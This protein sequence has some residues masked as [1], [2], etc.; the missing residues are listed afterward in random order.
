[1]GTVFQILGIIFLVIVVV[2]VLAYFLIRRKLKAIAKALEGCAAQASEVHL[3]EELR[4]AWVTEPNV[5]SMMEELTQLGFT[6]GRAYGIEEMPQVKLCTFFR[7]DPAI[8]CA[9]YQH[10]AVGNWVDLVVKYEDGTDITVT[11]APTGEDV[12]TRPNSTKVFLKGAGLT[13]LCR[14][15]EGRLERKATRDIHDA[16]FKEIFEEA[17][18]EDM[19]WR[20]KRGGVTEEEVRRI[21]QKMDGEFDDT[22][23]EEAVL[24]I[25]SGELYQLH[26]D[27]IENFARQNRMSAGE[28]GHDRNA[29]FVVSD[30]VDA[31]SYVD[32]LGNYLD[33]SYE[34]TE[35]LLRLSKVTRSPKVLFMKGNGLLPRKSRATKVGSVSS[36]IDADIY[37]AS[38]QV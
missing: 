17:Y 36:P 33:F 3:E 9:L 20:N 16:N 21:A 7:T 25:K 11:N 2:V 26:E 12:D 14:E 28:D 38:I 31:A 19:E 27:C 18:R 37:R 34:M 15:L 10:D 6:R 30:Q 1:M 8:A 5:Q 35:Q 4:P 13:E 22:V 32:Y 23:I 24:Q 29:L